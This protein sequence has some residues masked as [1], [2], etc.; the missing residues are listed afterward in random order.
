MAMF[1]AMEEAN[2]PRG[3]D[4][5]EEL[6]Y[7]AVSQRQGIQSGASLDDNKAAGMLNCTRFKP[8]PIF[9][10]FFPFLQA[11]QTCSTMHRLQYSL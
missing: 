2:A 4:D 8:L 5:E 1:W 6:D 10:F 9:S 7:T 3:W 11:T